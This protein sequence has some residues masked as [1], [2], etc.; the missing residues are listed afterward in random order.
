MGRVQK[1]VSENVEEREAFVLG[2]ASPTLLLKT[3]CE[4]TQASCVEEET[5]S[6][7]GAMLPGGYL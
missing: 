5:P 4:G 7:R 6:N 1:R 3:H 2:S